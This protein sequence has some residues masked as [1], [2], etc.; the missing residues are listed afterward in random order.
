M[1]HI[2]KG[3]EMKK[4]LF[5]LMLILLV[6]VIFGCG[7]SATGAAVV[8]S[9][10]PTS[11]QSKLEDVNHKIAETTKKKKDMEEF[12]NTE[13]SLGVIFE[14]KH[15][16]SGGWIKSDHTAGTSMSHMEHG[17]R[18]DH[19][20]AQAAAAEEEIVRINKQLTKLEE[21]KKRIL[22]ES[23]GC[24]PPDTL[25]FLENGSTKPFAKIAVGD[26]V[27]TYDIGHEVLIGKPVVDLY[28]LE[29]NHIYTI[30]GALKTTGGERLLSQDGWKTIRNLKVGDVVHVN[31]HMVGIDSIQMER[32]EMRVVNMQ[33]AETH[34]FYVQAP[35]GSKYL[36]HNSSGG[37]GGSGG[38]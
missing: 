2:K 38:K 10:V 6:V 32:V 20:N 34:N 15:N 33:V 3:V 16:S 13:R 27:M 4:W 19:H 31:G 18:A 24:F 5:G 22:A 21:E 35:D 8:K 9:G 25:V 28:S 26:L 14:Q 29:A 11:P 17:D 30:N 23:T 36:V 37:G 12:A 7:Y 1:L